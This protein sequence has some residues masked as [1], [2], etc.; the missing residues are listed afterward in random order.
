MPDPLVSIKMITYNHAPL[1]AQ[2]IEGV[3]QQKT[4]FPIELVIG[5]VPS[6]PSKTR[7]RVRE[8]RRQPVT[9]TPRRQ[10]T[11]GLRLPSRRRGVFLLRG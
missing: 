5:E 3:L 8:D 2:A 10:R 11:T 4:N 9:P 7:C 6:F 1:I